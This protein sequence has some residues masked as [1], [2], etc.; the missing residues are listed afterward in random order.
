MPKSPTKITRKYKKISFDEII[1]GVY[2]SVRVTDDGMIPVSDLVKLITQNNDSTTRKIISRIDP[3]FFNISKIIERKIQTK[4][5]KERNTK[6]VRLEDA[7][8]LIMI[9]PGAA[10]KSIRTQMASKIKPLLHCSN[11]S[12]ANRSRNQTVNSEPFDSRADQTRDDQDGFSEIVKSAFAYQKEMLEL[13]HK[14]DMETFE[15]EEDI[16]NFNILMEKKME[17]MESEKIATENS[18]KIQKF[19]LNRL[20][21]QIQETSAKLK[22]ERKNIVKLISETTIL[23]GPRPV[24]Y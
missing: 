15:D 4:D 2:S 9:L 3:T 24:H 18:I 13:Q 22:E 14:L 23:C 17:E 12:D 7:V 21:T 8:D 1:K 16:D 19:H 11:A 10:A 20:K 6:C 5:G